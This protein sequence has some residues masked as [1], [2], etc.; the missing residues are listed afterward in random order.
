VARWWRV[1][2]NQCAYVVECARWR[3]RWQSRW[4]AY[5]VTRRQGKGVRE[6]RRD[7]QKEGV[8]N[9]S[10]EGYREGKHDAGAPKSCAV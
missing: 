1:C 10:R 6:M 5:G 3:E 8:K 9:K 7:R 2:G 4:N